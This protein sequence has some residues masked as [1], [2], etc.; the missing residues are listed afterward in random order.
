MKINTADLL[1]IIDECIHLTNNPL[2]L[3]EASSP[4][5]AGENFNTGELF[6][7]QDPS[8]DPTAIRRINPRNV[9]IDITGGDIE[10]GR[11]QAD[12]GALRAVNHHILRSSI[13]TCYYD[14]DKEGKPLPAPLLIWG[15]PGL[16]KSASVKSTAREIAAEKAKEKGLDFVNLSK[17]R[18]PIAIRDV[19]TRKDPKSYYFVEWD[20]MDES[21]K[22]LLIHGPRV[23][24]KH[25]TAETP[26]IDN[27]F[28]FFDIRV[29]GI[30]ASDVGGMPTITTRTSIGSGGEET[31]EPSI[32]MSKI[33]FIEFIARNST[34]EGIIM[35]DELNQGDARIQTM[36]YKIVLDRV[37][38]NTPMPAGVGSFAAANSEMWGW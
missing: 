28:F 14:V 3:Q 10:Y 34:M 8:F 27:V 18:D 38:G 5:E 31:T 17:L 2:R 20:S 23:H 15:A 12:R 4:A 36:M 26:T 13:K 21:T 22:E 37:I 32:H 9:E 25:Q 33:P 30:E 35:W 19:L 11:I 24:G 7:I 29:A 1:N 16:G 6:G